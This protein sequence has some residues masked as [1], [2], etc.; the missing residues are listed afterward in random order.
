M[1][2]KAEIK[3]NGNAPSGGKIGLPLSFQNY[4]LMLIG[5]VIIVA[6]FILMSGGKST[7]PEIFTGDQLYNFRRITLAPILVVFG[8][9]FEIY[10]IMKL[11]KKQKS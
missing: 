11:P 6:G 1:S 4:K 5:F 8:F 3:T 9:M 2:K 10:A 7:D